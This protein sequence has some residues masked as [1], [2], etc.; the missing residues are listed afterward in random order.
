MGGAHDGAWMPMAGG[1]VAGAGLGAVA[2][3]AMSQHFFGI[4]LGTEL[5]PPSRGAPA[6]R[7]RSPS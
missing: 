7:Y 5:E 1:G 2:Y 4:G 3:S 6:P